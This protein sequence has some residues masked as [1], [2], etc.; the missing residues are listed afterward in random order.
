MKKLLPFL[1]TIALALFFAGC[2]TRPIFPGWTS[3]PSYNSV[4]DTFPLIAANAGRIFIYR[5]AI[6]GPSKTPAVLLNGEPIGLSKAQGFFYVDQPAG[7][8]KV[9]LSGEG[10]PPASFTLSAGQT[11]Y[12]RINVH[13]NLSQTILYP[14]VVDASVAGRELTACKYTPGNATTET[15]AEPAT[16][17]KDEPPAQA[18]PAAA[19]N[20]E[21]PAKMEIVIGQGGQVSINGDPISDDQLL[22]LLKKDHDSNPNIAVLIK[23]DKSTQLQKMDDVINACTAA[24]LSRFTLQTQ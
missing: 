2:T 21:S 5:D 17:N 16:V 20:D 8:D 12:V 4:K 14:E 11:V 3:G 18:E 10:S 22:P 19:A 15:P 6:Y 13:T 1:A 23:A 24:G 7:D 9:E